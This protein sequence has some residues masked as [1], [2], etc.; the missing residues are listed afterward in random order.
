MSNYSFK[1]KAILDAATIQEQL[2]KLGENFKPINIDLAKSIDL[3]IQLIAEKYLK[4]AIKT[5]K[6]EK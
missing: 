1:V 6:N 5:Y 2:N 3:N 4:Q